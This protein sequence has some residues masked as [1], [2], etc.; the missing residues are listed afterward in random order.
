VRT[1]KRILALEQ[2]SKYGIEPDGTINYF[3]VNQDNVDNCR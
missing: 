2:R 3:G 1:P